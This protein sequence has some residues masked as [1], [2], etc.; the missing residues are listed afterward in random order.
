LAPV[1]LVILAT[2][3]I[4]PP[5]PAMAE[6]SAAAAQ[7]EDNWLAPAALAVA[8]DAKTLFIACHK[9]YRV[10]LFDLALNQSIRSYQ[11]PG[12]PSG[13]AL[14][15]ERGR[16]YVACAGPESGICEIDL[17]KRV[18]VAELPAGHTALSPVLS[19]DGKRLFACLRFNNQVAW[20]DTATRR[21]AGRVTVGREPVSLALTRNGEFLFVAHHLPA[22]RADS[23]TVAATIGIVDVKEGAMVKELA[24]PNGSSIVR[25]IRLSPDGRYAAVTHNLAH[26]QV[27]ATQLDRGW[28]NTSALTVIAVSEQKILGTVT[29]DEVDRG[30]A[31]PWAL[32]WT[33]DGTQ[34]LVTHAGTH[35]LSVIDFSWPAGEAHDLPGEAPAGGTAGGAGGERP[36]FPGGIV[37]AA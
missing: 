22:G 35:E 14:D 12:P 13:L 10:E 2:S 26:F 3:V 17:G 21:E 23:R 33:T 37:P 19:G 25:E 11:M 8:A 18:V 31:N 1:L 34:L 7:L 9:A 5:T 4:G 6:M 20:W 32:G 36:G 15:W 27:P 28:L 29:L 16:L 24:L 30:A